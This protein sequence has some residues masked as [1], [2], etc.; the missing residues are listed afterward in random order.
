MRDGC[1][2]K[3]VNG[4]TLDDVGGLAKGVVPAAAV[5]AVGD[6]VVAVTYVNSSTSMMYTADA[7]I[8][9]KA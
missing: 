8:T 2:S 4:R 6:T 9:A 3:T 1:Q 7:F 5:P